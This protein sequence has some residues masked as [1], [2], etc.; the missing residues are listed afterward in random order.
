M[1]Y[2]QRDQPILEDFKL[3]HRV[4]VMKKAQACVRAAEL[5]HV[6]AGARLLVGEHEDTA[7]EKKL[8][9]EGGNSVIVP[10]DDK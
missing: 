5:E 9:S 7:I 6:R 1:R 2:P 8:V 4:V 3:L 10:R